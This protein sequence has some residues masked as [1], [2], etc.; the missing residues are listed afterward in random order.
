MYPPHHY[1]GYELVWH[2]AVEHL[3]ARGH[4]VRVL[5]TDTRTDAPG[6]DPPWVYRQLR[7]H[8]RDGQFEPLGLRARAATARHNHAVLER[9]LAE[10]RPEM[11]AWW[12]MGGLSLTMLETVRRRGLAAAA[13]VHDEWLG[14][15]R[16]AD[17]WLNTFEGP[18]RSR[19][20]RV[21]ERIAGVPTSV[22]FGAAAK[23]I[24]VSDFTRRRALDFGVGLQDTG[25]ASSGIHPD[26]LHPAPEQDWRWRLLYVG[27]ID[28]RKGVD[29]AVRALTH[30]PSEATL[31]AI[32]GWDASETACME[33][34]AAELGVRDRVE[35]DGQRGRE[36]LIEAY[37]W[38]DAVVFPVRWDEPWGLVPLEAM[39][40]GRPVVATGR[41]GSG[42]YLRD[43]ENCL[44]FGADDAEA[45]AASL[46][47]LSAEPGL[48]SRL[49]EHGFVD[50][51]EHTE[52]IFNA[53]VEAAM[54]ETVSPIPAQ[55]AR[56]PAGAC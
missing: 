30:L 55:P 39:G 53:A 11:V 15:G 24:F 5:A 20:A 41:G 3:R 50:A 32:G 17:A 56:E 7:W 45:L 9:H 37:G 52:P 8:L 29:T 38:A 33:R 44:L 51:A 54:L 28:P 35:L 6:E 34:L 40:R 14:Y 26:F 48:R 1:G 16:W 49:R 31:R 36:E 43:G 18:R 23:Y 4:E 19:L 2:S 21:G 46:R 25:V 12:S 13:F 10:F 27:R 22:D 47:R 42:E